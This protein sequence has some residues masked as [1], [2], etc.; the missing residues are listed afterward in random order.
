MRFRFLL[1][2]LF[3]LL[4]VVSA[5]AQ[6]PASSFAAATESTTPPVGWVQFCRDEPQE[7]H[8]AP[9]RP[10]AM[11]LDQ[12]RWKQLVAVNRRVNDE[13]EPVSDLEQWGQLERW[14]I[15]TSGKGDCEDYVIEKRRQLIASGWPRQALLITVVRDRKGDGHAV[16]TVVTDK[17]DLVLDNQDGRV[18]PWTET[19]YRF[20]KRQ[21]QEHPDRWVSLGSVDT[22]II[23]ANR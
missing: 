13:V 19:G 17:G 21:S 15:P 16:L 14:S 18:K 7:C 8:V 4:A 3:A 20:V 11:R 9:R 10:A 5:R 6:A 2:G 22:A 23:T 1:S 12:R